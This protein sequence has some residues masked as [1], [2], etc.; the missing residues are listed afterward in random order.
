MGQSKHKF[1]KMENNLT[2]SI[3]HP[4]RNI[5]ASVILMAVPSLFSLQNEASPLFLDV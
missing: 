3:E 2:V 5:S 1:P 4:C